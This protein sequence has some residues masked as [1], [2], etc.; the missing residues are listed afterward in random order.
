MPS[1]CKK[2]RSSVLLHTRSGGGRPASAS[3]RMSVTSPLALLP[4]TTTLASPGRLRSAIS[5][6][7][8]SSRGP[9][10]TA[11]RISALGG[12]VGAGILV[13]AGAAVGCGATVACGAAGV[14]VEALVGAGVGGAGAGLHAA[15]RQISRSA[16]RREV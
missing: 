14:L 10:A 11:Q 5:C 2:P 15:N 7:S 9:S 8:A 13:I 1:R 3:D 6:L 4:T 12:G 16:Q